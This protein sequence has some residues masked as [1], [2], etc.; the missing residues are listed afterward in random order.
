MLQQQ[1]GVVMDEATRE[2]RDRTIEALVE[3]QIQRRIDAGEVFGRP[4]SVRQLV[5][6]DICEQARQYPGW[7]RKQAER[8]GL[9]GAR[10]QPAAD[11]VCEL[12]H[13]G[14]S[15]TPHATRHGKPYCSDRCASTQTMSLHEW[16]ADAPE[17]HRALWSRLK[18]STI[19]AAVEEEF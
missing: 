15:G 14:M 19:A 11:Y 9:A 4:E 10:S 5:R 2:L 6:N 12:C 17:E 16:L 7:L 8:L 13:Q 1:S 18:G 3:E